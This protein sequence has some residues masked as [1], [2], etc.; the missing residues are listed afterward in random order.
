MEQL[1]AH[2]DHCLARLQATVDD[3]LLAGVACHPHRL[4]AHLAFLIEQPDRRLL[5]VLDSAD[6]GS[7][8]LCAAGAATL[9]LTTLPR[10]ISAGTE[11]RPTLT[12]S[13]P[14]RSS[15]VGVISRTLPLAVTSGLPSR[16]TVI[17]WPSTSWLNNDS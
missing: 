2:R 4:Q 17:R 3:H 15:T 6:Q 7:T 5:A 1:A 14:L 16:L 8:T 9:A 13:V 10:L 12:F 11:S